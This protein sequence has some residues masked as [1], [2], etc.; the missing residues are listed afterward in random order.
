M[1]RRKRKPFKSLEAFKTALSE[2]LSRGMTFLQESHTAKPDSVPTGEIIRTSYMQYLVGELSKDLFVE[3]LNVYASP[4]ER[5]DW[6]LIAGIIDYEKFETNRLK[7]IRDAGLERSAEIDGFVD[8]YAHSQEVIERNYQRKLNHLKMRLGEVNYIDY[9]I[10]DATLSCQPYAKVFFTPSRENEAQL[11]VDIRFNQL[12]IDAL[13]ERDGFEVRYDD[14]GNIVGDY[15]IE[16][17]FQTAIIV[18]AG[19]MMKESDLD[20]F[21]SIASDHPGAELV[22]RLEFDSDELPEDIPPEDKEKLRHSGIY[23]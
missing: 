1:F 6:L 23:K 19:N 17:W 3:L 11:N 18:M 13:S 20:F 8:M 22:Q 21:R 10:E 14:D 7:N 15:L 2:V 5:N 9:E 4:T 12:F 16:Q